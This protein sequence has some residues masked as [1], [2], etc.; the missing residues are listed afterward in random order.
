MTLTYQLIALA[1]L[2]YFL[3]SVPFGLLVGKL[4]GI[5]VREHG[6]K[7]IGATNVGRL[8]GMK[9]FYLVT[10][11][12]AL[13]SLVP[14]VLASA[15]VH[16][17]PES[18]RTALIHGLWLLT[19]IAAVLGHIF[20]VFLGF[21][22]GKGVA[23]GAGLVAL[24]T[25]FGGVSGAHFNPV[26]SAMTAVHGGLSRRDLPLYVLAQISG[27]IVGVL[28]AH[29]M[30]D[31]P[32]MQFDGTARTGFPQ[33]LSEVVATTGLLLVIAGAVRHRAAAVPGAVAG[34]VTAGYWFTAST[35]F[36]NPAVT[37][38]RSGTGTFAGIAPGDA[39][40]FI[41]AQLAGLAVGLGL[42]RLIGLDTP[43]E[44]THAA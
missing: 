22:G 37:I 38:A 26:V 6:S 40:G 25:T 5:D 3:G 12:D 4:K 10:L 18:E 20:P 31:L 30:F 27:G 44:K 15:L 28:L 7:N 16:R 29:A 2:A 21:K 11:L 13:K 39:P 36:A 42:I 19:G 43:S 35:C 41:L 32:L 14:V 1:V 33:W 9:F 24:I 8:L 23:T 34:Y 17:L